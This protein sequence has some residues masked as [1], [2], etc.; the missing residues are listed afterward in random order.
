MLVRV[1]KSPVTLR[2]GGL[3][4][5]V[6]NERVEN[7]KAFHL[8]PVYPYVRW[9]GVGEIGVFKRNYENKLPYT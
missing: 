1:T 9:G 8:I 6:Q 5:A 4:T 2:T 7:F 3:S